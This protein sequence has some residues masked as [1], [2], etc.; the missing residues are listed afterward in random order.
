[1]QQAVTLDRS[2]KS[3][4][5]NQATEVMWEYYRDHKAQIIADIKEFRAFI[6]TELMQGIPAEQIFAQYA[7]PPAPVSPLRRAP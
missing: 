7:R 2:I 1:M 6:L 3:L 4:S 5:E